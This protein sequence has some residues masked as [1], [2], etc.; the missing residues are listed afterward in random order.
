MPPK[1]SNSLLIFSTCISIM[2][3][4]IVIFGNPM[5]T[6]TRAKLESTKIELKQEIKDS[7]LRLSADIRE[8]RHE[9]IQQ[10]RGKR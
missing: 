7:E 1:Y 4:I 5:N 3:G 6:V 9:V 8:L 2:V 10:A